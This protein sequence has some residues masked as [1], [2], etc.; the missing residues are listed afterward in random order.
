MRNLF[1]HEIF[2]GNISSL[3]VRTC[4]VLLTL[5]SSLS[6]NLRYY[7]QC[8]VVIHDDLGCKNTIMSDNNSWKIGIQLSIQFKASKSLTDK[9]S[10]L[11]SPTRVES[12][13]LF[14]C[15][16]GSCK[17]ISH[18]IENVLWELK[19]WITRMNY[20]GSLELMETIY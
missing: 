8:K 4:N 11:S 3:M 5:L 17:S 7:F 16:I 10:W 13:P 1:S 9:S 19:T 20:I 2:W 15:P 18:Q 12:C 6:H 14:H